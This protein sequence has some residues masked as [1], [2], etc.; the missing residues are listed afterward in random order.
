M[1]LG[2]G[3]GGDMVTATIRVS[4]V[5]DVPSATIALTSYVASEG[6][7]LILHG[8]GLLVGDLDAG[9]STVRVTLRVGEGSLTITPGSTGV[10][11][12][13]SGSASVTVEG[14]LTQ[15][16]HVLA[17]NLGA[18]ITYEA[19]AVTDTVLTLHIDD[20]GAAGAGGLLT[21][22]A[23]APLTISATV[24]GNRSPTAISVSPNA[25]DENNDTRT[26]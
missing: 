18:T 5:N 10:A 3:L 26:G 14:T 9:A 15:I 13:G 23:T 16:N 12:S 25:V 17:G 21:A 1:G 8:T 6:T 22:T 19:S 7:P 20:L 11:V 24:A 2:S 4:P